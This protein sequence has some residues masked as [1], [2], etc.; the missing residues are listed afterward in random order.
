L[1]PLGHSYADYHDQGNRQGSGYHVPE[2]AQGDVAPGLRLDNTYQLQKDNLLF[3][4]SL[5]INHEQP[6]IKVVGMLQCT[7]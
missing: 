1:F 3:D 4:S 6:Y 2:G 7:Y 5:D